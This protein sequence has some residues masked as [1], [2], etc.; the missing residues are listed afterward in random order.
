M[1]YGRWSA[2]L[3]CGHGGNEGLKDLEFDH[4]KENFR[5]SILDIH[6]STIED[7]VI[8]NRE[9]WWKKTLMTSTKEFGYNK[10]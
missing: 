5:Y 10:N 6:K 4:I 8:I 1:L 2:Y 7:K 3:E 9:V